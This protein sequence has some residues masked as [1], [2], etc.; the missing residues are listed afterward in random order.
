MGLPNKSFHLIVFFTFNVSLKKWVETGLIGRELILYK[1]MFRQGSR[2]TLLT[3]GNKDDYQYSDMLGG[4]F[5][6]IFKNKDF[7][8]LSVTKNIKQFGTFLFRTKENFYTAGFISG[9][10]I[11]GLTVC[12]FMFMY[13]KMKR[14]E[15]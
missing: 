1:K 6:G 11:L 8:F 9:L 7:F 10:I 12:F 3:Y 2:V 5:Y 14:T 15:V 4:I 13:M